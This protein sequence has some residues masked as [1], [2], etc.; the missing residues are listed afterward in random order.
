MSAPTEG[1]KPSG[2]RVEFADIGVVQFCDAGKLSEDD[3]Q[4]IRT[5]NAA[6]VTPLFTLSDIADHLENEA[7]VDKVSLYAPVVAD[8]LRSL[9]AE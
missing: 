6:T 8:Y 1:P 3:A 2:H 4:K 7:P 9:E 5:V